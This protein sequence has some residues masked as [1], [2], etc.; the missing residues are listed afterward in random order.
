[1][2]SDRSFLDDADSDTVRALE[3]LRP[4]ATEPRSPIP[5]LI[6]FRLLAAM[7]D[8]HARGV[9]KQNCIPRLANHPV[10]AIYFLLSTEDQLVERLTKLSELGECQNAWR[11]TPRRITISGSYLEHRDKRSLSNGDS[12]IWSR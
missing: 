8:S 2:N 3:F 7:L 11:L 6:R 9:A 5:E 1:V 10:K 4:H 12:T